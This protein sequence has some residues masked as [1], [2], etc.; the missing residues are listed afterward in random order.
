[1]KSLHKNPG[2]FVLI[3]LFLFILDFSFLVLYFNRH[4][5]VFVLIAIIITAILF[6]SVIVSLHSWNVK[7]YFSNEEI[8]YHYRGKKYS[9]RW[10]DIVSCK[11]RSRFLARGNPL[12]LYFEITST[13]NEKKMVFEYSKWRENFLLSICPLE[14]LKDVLAESYNTE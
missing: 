6:L 8:Y 5:S 12:S 9:W 7:I 4:E 3:H 1:M 10:E 13:Q 2:L 14:N 11:I